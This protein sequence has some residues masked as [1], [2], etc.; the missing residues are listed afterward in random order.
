MQTAQIASLPYSPLLSPRYCDDRR[1]RTQCKWPGT[2]KQCTAPCAGQASKNSVL[3]FGASS[4]VRW[5]LLEKKGK[6]N[7][8]ER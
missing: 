8:I 3:L 6:E 2:S 5:V 4:T 7:H 1:V